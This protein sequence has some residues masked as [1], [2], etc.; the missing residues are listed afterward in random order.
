MIPRIVVILGLGFLIASLAANYFLFRSREDL[1]QQKVQAELHA[2]QTQQ[3]LEVREQEL[4][5]N[6]AKVAQYQKEAESL[7]LQRDNYRRKMQEA[8]KSDDEFSNWANAPVPV[9]VRESFKQLRKERKSCASDSGKTD[10]PS[11][12]I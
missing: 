10:T 12:V 3:A 8:L 7:R 6:D 4:K 1:A 5:D 11:F 2:E 9:F